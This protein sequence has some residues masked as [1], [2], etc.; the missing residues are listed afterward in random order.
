MPAFDKNSVQLDYAYAINPI[1]SE[2]APLQPCP[3]CGS[4]AARKHRSVCLSCKHRVPPVAARNTWESPLK[5][6]YAEEFIEAK[7]KQDCHFKLAKGRSWDAVR[8]LRQVAVNVAILAFAFTAMPHLCQ[9]ALGEEK[10]NQVK[11]QISSLLNGP[12]E[13]IAQSLLHKSKS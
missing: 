3:R 10:T 1:P 13:R 6:M 11:D 12:P 2:E 4:T 5:N 7:E 8:V 9:L